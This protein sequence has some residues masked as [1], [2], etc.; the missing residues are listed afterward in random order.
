MLRKT[1]G[2]Y[3]FNIKLKQSLL[4]NVVSASRMALMYK[5]W[6]GLLLI[7]CGSV[8]LFKDCL[9]GNIDDTD[10][11]DSIRQITQR[12][13]VGSNSNDAGP[14]QVLE[15]CWSNNG[16]TMTSVKNGVNTEINLDKCG[17]GL[18]CDPGSARYGSPSKGKCRKHYGV[19]CASHEEC[20]RSTKSDQR[21][22]LEGWWMFQT[23][24]WCH[25]DR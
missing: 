19:P 18:F 10:T 13:L 16:A 24:K 7:S 14:L 25:D 5:I 2:S 17:K 8:Y 23:Y 4:N 9:I 22:C 21:M 1:K 11:M 12:Q 15:A 20:A 6:C 3:S